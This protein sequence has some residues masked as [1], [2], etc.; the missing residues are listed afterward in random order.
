MKLVKNASQEDEQPAVQDRAAC[1]A[2]LDARLADSLIR[3]LESEENEIARIVAGK[4]LDEVLP[5]P[6]REYTLKEPLAELERDRAQS[7]GC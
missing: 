2:R 4:I 7:Y 5:P 6:K 3:D 1:R